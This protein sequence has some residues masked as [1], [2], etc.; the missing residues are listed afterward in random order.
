MLRS[1]GGK[2]AERQSEGERDGVAELLAAPWFLVVLT[3]AILLGAAF[4]ALVILARAMKPEGG[5]MPLWM[6]ILV[7][8][9][10]LIA[11]LFSKGANRRRHRD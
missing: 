2:R 5:K 11:R 1:V 9:V 8:P 3:L 6:Q 10:A 7:L 4:L